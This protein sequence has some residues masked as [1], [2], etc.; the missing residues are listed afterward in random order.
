MPGLCILLLWLPLKWKSDGWFVHW[1]C[2]L[3]DQGKNTIKR[4]CTLGVFWKHLHKARHLESH[5]MISEGQGLFP[6]FFKLGLV[7]VKNNCYN[8]FQQYSFISDLLMSSLLQ[9][10][11][12]FS[13]LQC[14]PLSS[15]PLSL[16]SDVSWSG[17]WRIL[18]SCPEDW[19]L[20]CQWPPLEQPGQ[21]LLLPVPSQGWDVLQETPNLDHMA[22][23]YT[24]LEDYD[25]G[26][27]K[28]KL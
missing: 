20:R 21:R 13:I 8:Y 2:N 26:Q 17:V 24:A 22:S 9:G 6:S 18:H 4:L 28:K 27:S 25:L 12:C 7:E 3:N 10:F 15:S 1:F 16:M 19:E 11:S 23:H 14:L 5:K